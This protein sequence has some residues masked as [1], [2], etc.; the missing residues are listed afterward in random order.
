[1][2]IIELKKILE[3]KERL[4]EQT[5]QVFLQLR[6]QIVLLKEMI[7]KEDTATKKEV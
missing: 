6:G 5:T 4:L 3:E 2:E 7:I 1:M